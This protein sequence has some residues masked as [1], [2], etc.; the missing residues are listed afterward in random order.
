MDSFQPYVGT[1]W[2]P[3][4]KPRRDVQGPSGHTRA[5]RKWEE[6]MPPGADPPQPAGAAAPGHL[7]HTSSPQAEVQT[8]GRRTA[9]WEAV[10]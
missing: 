10:S 2:G 7:L 8:L 4:V 5:A 9:L 3:L 6:W 1:S